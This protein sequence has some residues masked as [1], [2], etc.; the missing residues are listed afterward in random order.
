MN[1]LYCMLIQQPHPGLPDID[2][3]VPIDAGL[4]YLLLIA[5]IFGF[6]RIKKSGSC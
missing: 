3:D 5:A 1:Y 2:P 4:W 6:Y